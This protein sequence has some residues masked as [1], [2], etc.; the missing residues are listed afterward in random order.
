MSSTGLNSLYSSGWPRTR[1]IVQAD[2]EFMVF[3][4]LQPSKYRDYRH[5][6][7]YLASR[8]FNPKLGIHCTKTGKLMHRK[9]FHL[10]LVT[11]LQFKVRNIVIKLSKFLLNKLV[12]LI[13]I[14]IKFLTGC[15]D[16]F[17]PRTLEA[18]TGRSP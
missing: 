15:G 1:K 16:A 12:I 7:S 5:E 6:A 10:V 13:H 4:L 17:N 14:K 2:L 9:A 3:L 18:K 11:H 8:F